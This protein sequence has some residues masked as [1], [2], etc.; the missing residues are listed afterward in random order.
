MLL[1]RCHK[2]KEYPLKNLQEWSLEKNPESIGK[3][4]KRDYLLTYTRIS[5]CKKLNNHPFADILLIT[6][7]HEL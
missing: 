6:L 1:N 4:L 3:L 7:K 5:K 2:T